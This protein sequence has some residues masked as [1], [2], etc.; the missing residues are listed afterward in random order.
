[1]TYLYNSKPKK[2]IRSVGNSYKS[3]APF[4]FAS[5]KGDKNI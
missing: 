4:Y 2:E 3:V 5:E 1:M